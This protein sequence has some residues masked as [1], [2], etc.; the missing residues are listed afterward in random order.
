TDP[1][2]RGVYSEQ[3][4]RRINY[5]G[6]FSLTYGKLLAGKHRV[7]AVAGMRLNQ[8][9][10]VAGSYE[11][12]GF[13]GDDFP[14]A[15]FAYDYSDVKRAVYVES[16]ERSASQYLEKRYSFDDRFL[17]EATLRIDG[18]SVFGS[19]SQLTTI[20]S[21]GLA[22]NI[23][24]ESFFNNNPA[25]DWLSSLRIRASVG[26]PG[27]QNFSDYISARVYRYN[28]ENRNPFGPG[29]IISNYG[30]PELKWQKTLDRN[31]GF[32]LQTANNR[33]RL[34]FDYFVKTT[35]PLLVFVTVPSSAGTVSVT[36]N[37]GGQE[38]KGFTV[39]ANYALLQR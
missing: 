10:S 24:N 38:Q 8:V 34:F 2:K 16:K 33:V 7:N 35:D 22:W 18:A 29:V 39:T 30:N 5:D 1:L 23:H 4:E 17:L 32:D 28:N 9:S 6:D 31:I 11:V 3:N 21:M 19:S 14:N 25:Y 26:N 36:D 20:W 12:R 13:V 27:N 37:L 15:S